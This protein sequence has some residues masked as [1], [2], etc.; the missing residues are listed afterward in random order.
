M[1][2]GGGWALEASGGA[3]SPY[4]KVKG[5]LY[6]KISLIAE[7]IWLYITEMLAKEITN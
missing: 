1:G 7:P 5:C 3:T 6:R 2:K 4:M